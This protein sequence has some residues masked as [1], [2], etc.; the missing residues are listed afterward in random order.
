MKYSICNIKL[1]PKAADLR[2]KA[3]FF[4]IVLLWLLSRD[5][6]ASWLTS[7]SFLIPSFPGPTVFLPNGLQCDA[8]SGS[9]TTR[10]NNRKVMVGVGKNEKQKQ[11]RAREDVPMQSETQRK[12]FMYDKVL[13][14]CVPRL[15]SRAKEARLIM[16]VDNLKSGSILAVL[17]YFLYDVSFRFALEC[18]LERETKLGPD[19]S[20]VGLITPGNFFFV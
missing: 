6:M 9:V 5:A 19:L 18:Y 17:I 8:G 14:L 1:L 15:K 12:K 20:Q 7:S 13:S 10:R 2:K 3:V 11:I 4:I 16:E